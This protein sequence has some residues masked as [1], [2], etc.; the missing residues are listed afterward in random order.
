[1]LKRLVLR[2]PVQQVVPVVAASYLL[3]AVHNA[4]KKRMIGIIQQIP[5]EEKVRIYQGARRVSGSAPNK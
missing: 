4:V 2:A 5:P 1:M 3:L